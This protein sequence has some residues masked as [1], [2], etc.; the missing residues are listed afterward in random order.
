MQIAAF[1]A[2]SFVFACL[3]MLLWQLPEGF[4]PGDVEAMSAAYQRVGLVYGFTP[5]LAALIVV[6]TSERGRGVRDVLGRLFVFRIP[7]VWIVVALVLPVL[8]Q[9][10]GVYL[11]A[12]AFGEPL[13]F[14]AFSQW[15]KS[16]LAL[17]LINGLFSIG[18]ELGWRVFMLPRMLS[19]HGWLAAALL[20]GLLW[21]VWHFPLQGVSYF[22]L[23]D[24]LSQTALAL[25][26]V[27]FQGVAL[28][29]IIT[30][31]FLRT[32]QSLIPTLLL[33]GAVN[34]NMGLVYRNAS[35]RAFTDIRLLAIN[36]SLFVLVALLILLLSRPAHRDGQVEHEE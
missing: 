8:S 28:S 33:H 4:R 1:Y 3:A 12:E 18:E 26:L 27:T 9:W 29:V 17:A 11:W 34:A 16:F 24:S 30:A 13:R 15:L 19:R 7:L 21:S 10:L 6:F 36:A 31:I 35:D 2:L 14:P 25:L 32:R 20:T 23:T 22:A 5:T